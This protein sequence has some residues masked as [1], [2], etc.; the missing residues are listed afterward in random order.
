MLRFPNSN[1]NV[2][3]I[4]KAKGINVFQEFVIQLIVGQWRVKQCT[5]STAVRWDGV[6]LFYI[7]GRR[8]NSQQGKGQNN[9]DQ[10]QQTGTSI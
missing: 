9:G 8:H 7:A 1:L 4:V 2:K 5:I 6:S 10:L 3:N